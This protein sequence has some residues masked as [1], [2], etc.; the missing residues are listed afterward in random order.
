MSAC[1]G[2]FTGNN[3]DGRARECGYMFVRV[4]VFE[5]RTNYVRP[6]SGYRVPRQLFRRVLNTQTVYYYNNIIIVENPHAASS[7][8]SIRKV[9]TAT[10]SVLYQS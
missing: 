3:K 2:H 7:G 4:A 6:P 9:S 1:T 10:R 8:P 5:F